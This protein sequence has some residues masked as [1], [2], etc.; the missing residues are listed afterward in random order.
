MKKK[1]AKGMP[2]CR[3]N[4]PIAFALDFVG[5]KWTLIVLRDLIFSRKRYFQEFL[6]S[7]EKIASNILAA[8]LKLLEGAGLVTREADPAH[9]RRMIYAP[10]EKAL[11]LTPALLELLLW[12][13]KHHAKANA[14][15]EFVRRAAADRNSLVAELRAS[16]QAR[17]AIPR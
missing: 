6:D 14:P 7:N 16:N 1:T 4:C 17:R 2:E 13:T 15:Q 10:T 12:G 11:D 9:A 8:R 3:S 5:D